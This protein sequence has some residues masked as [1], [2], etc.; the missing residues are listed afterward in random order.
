MLVST[1]SFQRRQDLLECRHDF[2]HDSY[3]CQID[4]TS[5]RMLES[6]MTRLGS[7][8]APTNAFLKSV[9]PS[10]ISKDHAFCVAQRI[11]QTQEPSK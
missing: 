10:P 4:S 11:K 7:Q 3:P 5:A 1:A 8:L 9:A 6:A 2:P